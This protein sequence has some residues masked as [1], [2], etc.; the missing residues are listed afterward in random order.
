[1]EFF[2]FGMG[3][4][5]CAA[6]QAVHQLIDAQISISG[7]TRDAEKTSNCDGVDYRSHM[8]DGTKPGATLGKDLAAATHVIQSIAPDED[9]DAVLIH[10][11]ENLECSDVLEWLCYFSTVGVYGN[12]DGAWIDESAPCNPQN[13]RSQWRLLAEEQWRTFAKEKGVPLL[14]LRLAGIYGPGRSAFDRLKAGTARRI[15]KPGQVFNRIH[16][17][18]IGRVTALAAKAKLAGTFNLADDEPAPPQDVVAHAANMA[19]TN[20]PPETPFADADMTKMARSFYADNKR[21]SNAAIKSA[22][23]V[24]LL[25]PTYRQGLLAICGEQ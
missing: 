22:L 19:G 17:K 2:F 21:V 24:K 14:I 5:S 23:G 11:R 4:S 16:V 7:T 1:M 12:A 18:D 10:H 9:G 20:P 15:I 25:Y 13:K 8:F 3:Y 6:A